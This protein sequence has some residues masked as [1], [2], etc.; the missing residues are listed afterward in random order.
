MARRNEIV[1]IDEFTPKERIYTDLELSDFHE[2]RKRFY[3]DKIQS[4]GSTLSIFDYWEFGV[5]YGA[6]NRSMYQGLPRYTT[7]CAE[8]IVKKNRAGEIYVDSEHP[9][10]SEQMEN[11]LTQHKIRWMKKDGATEFA[12]QRDNEMYEIMSQQRHGEMKSIG[13]LTSEI[14]F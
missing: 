3:K 10:R 4:D 13:Q 8:R 7:I 6:F 12:Q 5:A 2:K 11:L 14:P 9:T 1:T